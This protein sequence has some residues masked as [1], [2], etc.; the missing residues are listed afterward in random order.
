M[1]KYEPAY[2]VDLRVNAVL[3]AFLLILYHFNFKSFLLWL[4]FK[5]ISFSFK[6]HTKLHQQKLLYTCVEILKVFFFVQFILCCRQWCSTKRRNTR[7]GCTY[8]ELHTNNDT[9][10]DSLTHCLRFYVDFAFVVFH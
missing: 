10:K 2:L 4:H 8:I 1:H 7:C 3:S 6:A 5:G 9:T